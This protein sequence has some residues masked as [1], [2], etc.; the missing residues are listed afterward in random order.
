[1]KPIRYRIYRGSCRRD[2]RP[3]GVLGFWRMW[4]SF[5]VML[6]VCASL[7]VQGCSPSV[8]PSPAGSR[9]DTVV[10]VTIDTWRR[11]ATGFLGRQQP[12]PT[13]F[14]DGLA[15]RGL[16][17]TDATA[18]VPH[19]APS[20]WS[21]LT[22]RWPWRDALHLNGDQPAAQGAA[23][24]IAP[25]LRANGF[26]T[27]AFVS[28][29][30]L[31]HRF[32][33]GE[34]F[35]H[36]DDPFQSTGRL[37]LESIPERRGDATVAAALG[38]MRTTR[39]A[40]RVLLW[41]HLFDPHAPYEAPVG[42]Y[43]GDHGDYLAEVAFADRQVRTL[44]EGLASVG[45]TDATTLWAVLSDH[46]EGLGEHGEATHGF[47]LHGAT[48]RIPL[49]FAGPK[50]AVGTH[51]GLAATVDVYPTLLRALGLEAA[52]SDGVALGPGAG[53]E[54]RAIPLESLYAARAFGLAVAIGMREG[55]LLWEAAPEDRLWN[56]AEDPL[57]AQ[58]L[59]ALR[60]ETIEDLRS[61][62]AT[63]QAGEQAESAIVQDEQTS[64]MLRSLGYVGGNSTPGEG[65]VR[66]FVAEGYPIHERMMQLLAAR[67][68]ANAETE[69]L[70]FLDR[71]PRSA[72]VWMQAGLIAANLGRMESAAERLARAVALDPTSVAAHQNLGT[73]LLSLNR[74]ADAVVEYRRA[75]AID[76]QDP[77]C[78]YN[79]GLAL[80]Q[81]G[82]RD[83]ART[84]WEEFL[85]LHP[86]HAMAPNVR[87]TLAG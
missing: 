4:R 23:R 25:T 26:R 72:S 13:P 14:L 1:M 81:I 69:A 8:P 65:D 60:K 38:W 82:K 10:L 62:R 78:L 42:A 64:A 34:G 52:E 54:D 28:A 61:R 55:S 33:F 19:T 76:P 80:W 57:E 18:P 63:F 2:G 35:E 66:E 67:Q 3:V 41:V 20:H 59:A 71:F 86:Q 36:Y 73:A 6:L 16:V 40:E 9:I 43:P 11:D 39:P 53:T 12:S 5:F 22:G 75:L 48:T 32:G 85:R 87:Q 74:P 31:D 77:S 79:V 46:G 37:G 21:V 58:D 70:A 15:A 50:I 47:L 30:V 68:P 49:L 27:A 24:G 84:A 17:A 51:D 83:E 45:R 44:A 29:A 7:F 56:L